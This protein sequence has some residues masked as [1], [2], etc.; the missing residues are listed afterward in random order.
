[1][2]SK[3]EFT[4]ASMIPKNSADQKLLTANPSTTTSASNIIRALITKRNSPK[5]NIVIGIVNKVSRGFSVAL[6]IASTIATINAEK[7]PSIV[8]P[9]S[10]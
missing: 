5:V 10:K 4:T 7:K 2:A 9:G 6:N 8:A 3:I 1:M